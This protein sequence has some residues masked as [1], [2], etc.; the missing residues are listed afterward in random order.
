MIAQG[1]PSLRV[2]LREAL[3]EGSNS[4]GGYLSA[5]AGEC[6]GGLVPLYRGTQPHC[7][8]PVALHQAAPPNRPAFGMLV[9]SRCV[10]A[11]TRLRGRR[12]HLDHGRL[13]PAT[14]PDASLP[15]APAKRLKEHA[16]ALA[17]VLTEE[18]L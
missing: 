7:T 2:G 13:T 12:I 8:A 18:R 16:A 4:A 1:V 14:P 5:G 17:A 3:R 11:S 6:A 10:L 15:P 9:Q